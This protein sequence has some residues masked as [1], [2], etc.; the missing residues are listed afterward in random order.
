MLLLL[1]LLLLVR[2]A[3]QRGIREA[4]GQREAVPY[5]S[6]LDLAR[7][8]CSRGWAVQ[9]HPAEDF[10]GGSGRARGALHLRLL[11]V[12]QRS[13][14]RL[15]RD[16][17]PSPRLPP[18]KY[19]VRAPQVGVPGV[20]LQ[21]PSRD[22][23]EGLFNTASTRI[24]RAPQKKARLAALE[25]R[26][27]NLSPVVFRAQERKKVSPERGCSVVSCGWSSRGQR[28]GKAS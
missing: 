19:P 10:L 20:V 27:Q 16:L 6:S 8:V 9:R 2:S 11:S 17:P 3:V 28:V 26:L 21:P 13:A 25:S 12:H 15:P 1:Y 5:L 14:L 18:S 23:G 4:Y 22:G 7:V 24:R